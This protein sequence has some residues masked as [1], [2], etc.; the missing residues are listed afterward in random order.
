MGR[1]TVFS[2][3]GCHRCKTAKASLTERNIPFAEICISMYPDKRDDM[4]AM[5]KQLN[6]PQFFFNDEHIGGVDELA[7]VLEV[8]DKEENGISVLDQYRKEIESV[9]GPTDERLAKPR[10]KPIMDS[11]APA[12]QNTMLK[13]PRIAGKSQ[14]I[15][16]FDITCKLMKV[17]PRSDLTWRGTIYKDAFKGKNGVDVLKEEFQLSSWNEA[18]TFGRM[19]Q[20]NKILS[21]VTEDHDFGNNSYFYRLQAYQEPNVLN[22]LCI[23]RDRV[24]QDSDRIMSMLTKLMNKIE[25]ACTDKKGFVDYIAAQEHPDFLIFDEASCE[26]QGIDMASMDQNTR[27]AF[28][29]N[30]YNLMVKHA[31]IKVGVPN[32]DIAKYDFFHKI[33]Y[34]IGGDILTSIE[35]ENGVL[36]ANAKAPYT[37]KE[38]FSKN[39]KRL[40]LALEEADPRIHF[41]LNCGANSCPPVQTYTSKFIQEE[42]SLAAIAFCEQDRNVTI[43]KTAAK[44]ELNL[45]KIFSWYRSDF[46]AAEY[47]LPSRVFCYLRGERKELLHGMIAGEKAINI[48]FKPY[49]WTPIAGRCKEFQSSS[50]KVNHKSLSAFLP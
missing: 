21:H 15:S 29:I 6:V 1:I 3:A 31:Y 43:K 22:T 7:V 41:A 47:E 42:L 25:S 5:S 30:A 45:S 28:G 18:V 12:R 13:L 44:K 48:T 10:E 40:K 20:R 38:I 49:D 23:W 4:V 16:Q 33:S 34:N 46:E 2:A 32:S 35:L 17:M 26:L 39:D 24:D 11:P 37:T 9:D 50:L 14:S 19:L 8:W 27:L 36:R